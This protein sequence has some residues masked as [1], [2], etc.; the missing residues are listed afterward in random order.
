MSVRA[1]EVLTFDEG[2]T[3]F[4][5]VDES[6]EDTWLSLLPRLRC[7]CVC[8]KVHAIKSHSTVCVTNLLVIPVSNISKLV[9]E[10]TQRERGSERDTAGERYIYTHN[11][12]MPSLSVSEKLKHILYETTSCDAVFSTFRS[13]KNFPIFTQERLS[14]PLYSYHKSTVCSYPF[15]SLIISVLFYF[16]HHPSFPHSFT[17]SQMWFLCSILFF[18]PYLYPFF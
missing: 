12:H 8:E 1:C 11:Q 7:S 13:S 2:G 16:F 14:I 17:P 10:Q 9:L 3:K 6:E 18:R 4:P 5:S 15:F